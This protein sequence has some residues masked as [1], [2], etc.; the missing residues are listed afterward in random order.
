MKLLPRFL[1]RGDSDINNMRKLRETFSS[2]LLLTNM[3][4]GGDGREIFSNP[5]EQL[6][7]K[8][9]SVGWAKTHFL[10]FST[11]EETAFHY[12]SL[13]KA[14]DEVYGINESWDFAV[15]SFDTSR[16]I[17]DSI[18]EISTGIY[19]AQFIPACKEF[20]PTYKL[21]LIDAVS[22]LKYISLQHH[23][24]ITEA[25]TKAN[26]DHEWLILPASP[27]GHNSEFT[28]KF[29]T[30]CITDRRVFRYA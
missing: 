17:Q 10:S 24:D 25:I 28:G 13:D 12:G 16:L 18:K 27:F 29:D 30:A 20:L 3:C 2:E 8:H 19:S 14:S 7:N 9:I 6:I 23:L 21:I 11:C 22:H 5:L 4:N 26:L 1:Y 15:F